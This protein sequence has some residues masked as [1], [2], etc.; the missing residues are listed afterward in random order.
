MQRK[1][2]I[3]YYWKQADGS[4]VKPHHKEYL[5][6]SAQDRIYSQLNDGFTSGELLDNLSTV[7]DPVDDEGTDYK[8]WWSVQKENTL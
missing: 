2:T 7:D 4:E 8:G 6:E 5:E 3:N 1:I